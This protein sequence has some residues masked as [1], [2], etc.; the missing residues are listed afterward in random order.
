[1]GE[2]ELLDKLP[3]IEALHAGAT[4]DG[5]REAARAAAERIRARL[6]EARV[7]EADIVMVYTLPDPWMR[8]LLGANPFLQYDYSH[9][10]QHGNPWSG[11]RLQLSFGVV[12]H[13]RHRL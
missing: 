7:H 2:A 9:L 12:R 11:R 3:K 1:M 13:R 5:E 6:A 4:S 8:K 10:C